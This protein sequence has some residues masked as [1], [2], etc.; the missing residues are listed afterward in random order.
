MT[1]LLKRL[2]PLVLLA[3]SRLTFAGEA[4]APAAAIVPNAAADPAQTPISGDQL[5]SALAHKLQARFGLG[6]ELQLSFANPWAEPVRPAKAWSIAI[7]E[8]PPSAGSSMVV[9]FQLIGD[10]K[11]V[12]EDTVILRASLWN[13]AWFAR[14]P[15]ASGSA[16]N[17]G[18]FEVHRI[19]SFQLRS[20]VP[21]GT[22]DT[23][24][25]LSRPIQAGAI[26]TWSDVGHRPLVKKGDIVEVSAR[27]G[28]LHVTLKGLAL[29]N[30][31]LGD[32]VTIR[33]PE[34]LKI[35]PALV[36]GENRAEVRL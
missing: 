33:N 18:Q 21:V 35:I 13:D 28:L 27:D 26:L 25:V 11:V 2:A 12:E 1:A 7:V 5:L 19:D 14:E 23:E 36:V 17:L 8:C 16:L 34:S 31:A 32:T 4:A 10:S 29:Q 20:A 30:G 15:L 9:R 6:G 3:L 24:F 22:P